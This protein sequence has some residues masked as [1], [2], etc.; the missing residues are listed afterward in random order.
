MRTAGE[1]HHLAGRIR[2]A[3]ATPFRLTDYEI[4]V[5]CSI[6]IALSAADTGDVEE[7]I[8]NAQFATKR[9]KESG[10]VEAYQKQA[11]TI[12]R[13]QFA[14]ET[15]LRRAIADRQLRLTYQPICNLATGQIVAVR[16]AG[17]LAGC[18]RA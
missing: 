15:A 11:F 4:A 10:E 18:H 2:R 17:T 5:D 13:E 1:A 6:G 3:L 8:R 12:A 16:I 9:A 14:M 7:L